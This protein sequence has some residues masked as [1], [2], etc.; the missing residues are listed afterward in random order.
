MGARQEELE[1]R[2]VALEYALEVLVNCLTD[3]NAIRPAKIAH[4]LEE[5]ASQ[6][7]AA[8]CGRSVPAALKHLSVKLS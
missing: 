1:A 5:A 3:A 7:K 2:I 8:T 4:L 6:A